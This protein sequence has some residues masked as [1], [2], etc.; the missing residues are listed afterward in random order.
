[1]HN[2]IFSNFR[3][4]KIFKRNF[5]IILVVIAIPVAGINLLFY[6]Y[7]RSVLLNKIT[8]DNSKNLITI[9]NYMDTIFAVCDREISMLYSNSN[10]LEYI[11]CA[12]VFS[13][14][15]RSLRITKNLT[16]T[17]NVEIA[18]RDY[19]KAIEIYSSASDYVFSSASSCF[20]QN[21]EKN[22]LYNVVRKRIESLNTT[23][24][25][26]E[27]NFAVLKAVYYN[28]VYLGVL[29]I[30][31]N[32]D[33][34]TNKISSLCSLDNDS[35]MLFSEDGNCVYSNLAA[36]YHIK[37]NEILNGKNLKIKDKFSTAYINNNRNIDFCV[38]SQGEKFNL[39]YMLLSHVYNEPDWKNNYHIYVVIMIMISIILIIILSYFVSKQTYQ[40]IKKL[41]VLI[42]QSDN[43]YSYPDVQTEKYKDELSFIMQKIGR[44]VEKQKQT[45]NELIDKLLLV[46]K[47]HL[48]TLQAQIKPH[49][50]Y[51]TIQVIAL[52]ASDKKINVEKIL[53]MLS[54]LARLLQ[55]T[56]INNAF[57]VRVKDEVEHAKCY[58]DLQLERFVDKF[59]VKWD[60]AP[61]ILESKVLKICLQPII[62]NAIDHG[63]RACNHKCKLEICGWLE[64]ENIMFT[65]MDDGAGISKEKQKELQNELSEEEKLEEKNIHVGMKNVNS[66]I[67]LIFGNE[68]GVT[69][70]SEESKFTKITLKMPCNIDKFN[71]YAYAER[72]G[73]LSAPHKQY[74]E[75]IK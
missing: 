18:D 21:K 62:E 24:V 43:Y 55:L 26:D 35:V 49:F 47:Y 14:N 53:Q 44:I 60:I 67:R 42:E 71:N 13:N 20:L 73:D 57:F 69:V 72:R 63:I 12:D 45:E 39:S 10:V 2:D 11:N 6:H 22:I 25:Y 50:L 70:Q 9:Q 19:I 4:N 46:K 61:D 36:N 32:Q 56:Y 23:I 41:M 17:L 59:E 7:N 40:P 8:L 68:Y 38:F 74:N 54:H 27:N 66:R 75:G 28:K 16:Q 48:S 37:K 30:N 51:N 58:V 52:Y 1:M 5:I 3:F 29:I 31:L 34:I 15:E 33:I 65:I 64:N